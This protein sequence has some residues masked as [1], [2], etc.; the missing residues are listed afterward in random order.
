MRAGSGSVRGPRPIES[1]IIWG[2]RTHHT[3]AYARYVCSLGVRNDVRQFY[4]WMDFR[5][6][7]TVILPPRHAFLTNHYFIL[8]VTD[9][10]CQAPRT[11]PALARELEII[12]YAS[13]K[14]IPQHPAV[15]FSRTRM[16]C[17]SKSP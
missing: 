11:R 7:Y 17:K 15:R 14:T 4:W 3:H 16:A 5:A 9:F 13:V 1:S 10:L 8:G 12:V 6:N 2:A